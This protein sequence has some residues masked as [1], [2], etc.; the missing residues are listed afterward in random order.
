[1]KR[2]LSLLVSLGILYLLYRH[3]GS[4]ALMT[5]ITR[6]DLLW[7][8]AAL[9]MLIPLLLITSWRFLLLAPPEAGI[10]FA[11]SGRLILV[12]SSMNMVLPSKLGDIAKAYFISKNQEIAGGLSLSLVLFEK[13]A[14]MLSLLVWCLFGL[15]FY[16]QKD[17]LFWLFTSAIAGGFGFGLLLMCSDRFCRLSF[18]TASIILPKKFSDKFR[19]LTEAL[20]QVR[21]YLWRNKYRLA[22]LTGSSVGLWFLHL[23]QIWLFALALGAAVPLLQNL[24]LAPLAILAGLVPLTFAGVG[25]RDAALIALYSPYLDAAGGAMLG[26]LCTLRYLLPAL[27]GIPFLHR[28]LSQL[29]L[30][31]QLSDES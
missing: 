11:E 30:R 15:F 25:T 22:V 17:L 7:L 16:P 31:R 14:D 4:G 8:G 12:S 18:G 10:D 2:L 19:R 5:A 9:A 20:H 24:A 29:R 26:L 28:Y 23:L 13:G 3:I 27:F 1:M 21:I 6:T